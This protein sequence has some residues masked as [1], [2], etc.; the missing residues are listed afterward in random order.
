MSG[1]PSPFRSATAIEAM[2]SSVGME[3]MRKRASGGS[4]ID[5]LRHGADSRGCQVGFAGLV[6]KQVDFCAQ[7]VDDN[8]VVQAVAVQIRRVQQTDSVINR[9]KSPGR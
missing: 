2:R 7:I 3:S 9:D 5:V 8:E 1:R 4:S 6:V